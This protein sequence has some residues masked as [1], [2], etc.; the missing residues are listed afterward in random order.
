M[1][2]I[3][4][5]PLWIAS[6]VAICALLFVIGGLRFRRWAIDDRPGIPRFS[7]QVETIILWLVYSGAVSVGIVVVRQ[8]LRHV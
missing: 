7:N 1:M 3:D 6:A 4:W 2:P 8:T 5:T